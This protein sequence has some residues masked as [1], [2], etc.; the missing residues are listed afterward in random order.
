MSLNQTLITELKMEAANT[1]QILERV[2]IDKNDWKPHQKS[3]ALGRLATHI[4]ETPGWV[5]TTMNS[6]TLDFAKSNYKSNVAQSNEELLRILDQNVSEAITAL[7]NAKDEDF[8]KMWTMRNGEQ[9]YFTL[10][11]KVVLRTYAFSNNFN[12]R[13]QLGVYLRLL[14]IPVP[15]MYGTTADEA[16]VQSKLQAVA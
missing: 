8:E 5:M 2:P 7:E 6:D 10:P 15:G 9:L 4:A 16:A 12:H 13:A 14:N 1:R 11:K 3:M